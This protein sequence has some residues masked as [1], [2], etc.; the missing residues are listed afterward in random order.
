MAHFLKRLE[1]NGFKSFAGKTVLEFPAGI[2]AIVGPNGSGKSNVVD[3]IRW[4]LGERDAKNLRGGKVED[5]IFA[6]T[7]KRARVGVAT[8]SLY[9][10]NKS[11]HGADG[12][13]FFPVDFEE[14]VVSRQVTRGGDSKYFLNKS[15]ILLRDLVDFFAK[16]RLGSRGMIIIGQGDSD[17]FIRSSP[18]ERREMIEEILGLREYQ[19]KKADAER[20]LKNSRINLDKTKALVEEILPHLRSLKRQTSRWERRG[21]LE[22]ELRGLENQFFGSQLHEL[23]EK[24]RAADAAIATN[25]QEFEMLEKTLHEAEA[26]QTK[27]EASQP[28]EKKELSRIKETVRALSEKR[29]DLQKDLGRLEAQVEMAQRQAAES[30]RAGG[31]VM[32]GNGTVAVVVDQDTEKL[33]D[34]IK[35]MK[36]ELELSLNEDPRELHAV[37]ETIIEEIEFLLEDM[38]RREKKAAA[39]AEV[40]SA[41]IKDDRN[42]RAGSNDGDAAKAIPEGLTREL[43]KLNDDLHA[44]EKELSELRTQEK[45]LE[46]S[47]EGF[48]RIFKEAVAA[49][50]T[51]KNRIGEWE[52][53]NRERVLEKERLDLRRDEVLRQI[54]QA[55]RRAE[56]FEAG[57]QKEGEPV[58]SGSELSEADRRIFRLRGELASIGEV[59]QAL[60]KEAQDTETRYAFLTKESEDLEKAVTDLTALMMELSEKIKTEFEKS[61]HKINEEFD[62][63]FGMMFGGG[64]SAKLKVQK[65]KILNGEGIEGEEGGGESDANKEPVIADVIDPLVPQKDGGIEIELKL[66]RK[67]IT[68]LDALSGGERS[69][70]G[71]AA[72]FAM[73]S[74][75]P[76]PFLV[77][78]EIDAPLDE[79]NARRFSDMLKEFSK[80]TQFIVVTHNRATM[81]AADILY[82]VTLGEDGSSKVVSLKLEN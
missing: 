78:D 20:R 39:K 68:S 22:E 21:A 50:Q 12:G 3:S 17:L 25:R 74:V 14:V 31:G 66:A 37:V 5:L 60:M 46:E 77:L 26:H 54:E 1:L 49:V 71:I 10:D 48:Y 42:E 67:R 65:P 38:A 8:A 63:F 33:I 55:G 76:P 47:Q 9:F 70:V 79:R 62:K 35:K 13:K 45:T 64:G 27:I 82:G 2:V 16:A 75:S 15:E 18:I 73:V 61:L 4:L 34:L 30:S 52:N 58:M 23:A 80:H 29:S 41:E 43:K 28:E 56:E 19:L 11:G 32:N 69:L 6:G 57:V 81:E 36:T 59:D 24:R 72:L 7:P 40:R 53:H 51:A 44:L